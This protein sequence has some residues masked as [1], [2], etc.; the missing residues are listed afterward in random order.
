MRIEDGPKVASDVIDGLMYR[1]PLVVAGGG[2]H[3]SV[4][5]SLRT[6]ELLR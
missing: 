5:Q 6:P 2:S 1:N 3:H 4:K